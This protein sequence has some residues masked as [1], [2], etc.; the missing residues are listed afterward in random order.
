MSDKSSYRLEPQSQQQLAKPRSGKI[1]KCPICHVLFYRRPSRLGTGFCSH[2]CYGL[3]SRTSPAE[4][5]MKHVKKGDHCWKWTGTV[6]DNGYG[7]AYDIRVARQVL[8]HRLS[9]ELFIGPIPE[10]QEVMHSC[11]NR[12]CV[13]PDHLEIGSHKKNME[14]AVARKRMW[15]QKSHS[16]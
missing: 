14:D 16:L 8:A 1:A 10:G 9:Y 4:L 7:Q 2:K 5:F 6:M 15:W 3:D 11:D 13:R 12:P